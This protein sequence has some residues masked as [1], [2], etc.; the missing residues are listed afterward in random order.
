MKKFKII[1]LF[2]ILTAFAACDRDE[3][4]DIQPY[5]EILPETVEDFRLM[6]NERIERVNSYEIDVYLSDEI[7]V[8]DGTYN[9][10]I[11]NSTSRYY[12][13]LTWD[14]M[15]GYEDEEDR[16]YNQL[17][18]AVLN[19]NMLIREIEGAVGSEAEKKKMIA[20]LKVHRAFAYFSLVNLYSTQY[21]EATAASAK[22]VP[23]KLDPDFSGATPRESVQAVYDVI[24]KDLSE[25]IESNAMET[26]VPKLN[27]Q[28]SQAAAYALLARVKL[29]MMNYSEALEAA[30]N[31]L[32]IY[33]TL[34][35]SGTK[36]DDIPNYDN[37]EIIFLKHRTEFD[38]WFATLYAADDL[39]ALY[40]ATNDLRL[41]DRYEK[42][43]TGYYFERDKNYRN[44]QSYTG[45]T[46][47]EMYLIRAECYSRINSGADFQ[48]AIDDLNTLRRT[49]YVTGTYNDLTTVQLPDAATT[50]AFVKEERRREMADQGM[51]LFDIKRYIAEGDVINIE[52]IIEGELHTPANN[53]RLIVPIAHIVM[54]YA[55][56]IEQSDR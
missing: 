47:P 4:L 34:Y 30:N 48:K 8:P 18:N 22:G 23:I 50:L 26:S 31:C 36:E 25:A 24:L 28:A 29:Q 15:F 2:I 51:R 17:Y 56:E 10:Y 6:L 16:E 7:K 45:C 27:W 40:D 43:A 53:N 9:S 19:S 37:A 38:D 49:R 33:N 35:D 46:V 21:V 12:N 3:L 20:E 32:G 55:P 1:Y 5:G 39:I 41:S 11:N 42:D 44:P 14:E 54:Q 52:R 13:A